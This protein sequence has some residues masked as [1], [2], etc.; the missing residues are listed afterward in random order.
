L[1]LNG[2]VYVLVKAA[3]DERRVQV[4]LDTLVQ[5]RVDPFGIML[6]ARTLPAISAAWGGLH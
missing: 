2:I 4:P 3:L 1:I 5:I 6:G